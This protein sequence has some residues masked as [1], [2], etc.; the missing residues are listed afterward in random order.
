MASKI[1][2]KNRRLPSC[3]KLRRDQSAC[4]G[5]MVAENLGTTLLL[6]LA[7]KR[8]ASAD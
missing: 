1:N 3:H 7:I 2:T 8:T 6:D 5:R 4:P